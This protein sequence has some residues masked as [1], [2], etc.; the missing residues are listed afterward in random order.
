M[1]DA[2]ADTGGFKDK[3]LGKAK[4]VAG[5]VLDDAHLKQ[6]GALHEEKAETAEE[7]GGGGG[8]RGG[9]GP[10]F[11]GVGAGCAGGGGRGGGGAPGGGERPGGSFGVSG[12]LAYRPFSRR[13]AS[14][15]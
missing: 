2:P 5:S 3:L 8:G 10:G 7:G 11:G 15:C 12:E 13:S 9:G 6:E 1:A 14:D 4:K